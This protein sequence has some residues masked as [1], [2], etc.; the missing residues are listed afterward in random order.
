MDDPASSGLILALSLLA[1]AFFS[2]MEIAFV[3]ANRLQLE[4]DAQQTRRGKLVAYLTERPQWLITTLLI[5][6]NLALVFC[7]IESGKLISNY[8]FQTED[9]MLAEH[10]ISTLIAQ[11]AITT[12]VVLVL[13]EFIP[14]SFFHKQPNRWLKIFAPLLW[15]I[16]HLLLLPGLVVVGITQGMIALTGQKK[17]AKELGKQSLGAIDLDHFVRQIS[18]RMHPEQELEHELQIMQ[19][20]LEFNK[21]RARDCLIPRNEVVAVDIE[22]SME[23]LRQ[24]FI[25]TGLS[26]IVVFKGDIDGIVGYVHSKDLFRQPETLKSILLPTLIIPEPMPADEVLKRFMQRRRHM[27]VVVDEFGG[28][29]GILT[30]EDIVEQLIGAIDDEFDVEERIIENLGEGAWRLS[31]RLTV[32]EINAT[33]GTDLPLDDA[34][35]TLGGLILHWA[36]EIPA[37]GFTIP[38]RDVI[39]EVETVDS[40]RIRVVRLQ[41]IHATEG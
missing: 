21:L 29:S 19:N 39:L 17:G 3:S 6:N 20:A 16:H 30:M 18:G 2:G 37:A 9:W 11:T 38:M 7:G 36:E 15:T 8:L 10:P 4:L 12:A 1:S 24:L 40:N 33:C 5:G 14:K 27:A 35:E 23:S 25:E 22:T 32:D 34:Y 28:T 26:K 41:N 13:A 31:A